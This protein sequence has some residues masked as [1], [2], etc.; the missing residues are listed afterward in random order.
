[1]SDQRVSYLDFWQKELKPAVDALSPKGR[2]RFAVACADRSA[3]RYRVPDRTRRRPSLRRM[4]EELWRGIEEGADAIDLGAH[5]RALLRLMGETA[6]SGADDGSHRAVC[7]VHSA[8]KCVASSGSLEDSL[9]AAEEA[10]YACTRG[11]TLRSGEVRT[12][13]AIADRERQSP[14]CQR[15]IA[16]QRSLLRTLERDEDATR[17]ELTTDGAD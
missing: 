2:Q 13:D 1:M 14:T 12:Y 15:E 5:H 3:L 10:F 11:E 17:S 7:A 8:G 6:E 4:S 9:H 16:Y